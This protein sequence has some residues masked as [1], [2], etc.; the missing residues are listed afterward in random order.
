MPTAIA[1]QHHA[2]RRR[3]ALQPA[4]GQPEQDRHAGDEAEQQRLLQAHGGLPS[5][6]LRAA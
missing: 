2:E 1:F 4:D 5:R 3:R 6:E